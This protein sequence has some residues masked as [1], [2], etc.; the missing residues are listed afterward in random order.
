MDQSQLIELIRTLKPEETAQIRH[1]A[2]I[3]LFTNGRMRGQIIPLLDICLS[4]A[5]SSDEQKLEKSQLFSKIFPGQ[6]FVEGKLE[7][8]MVEAHK[9]VRAFLLTQRYFRQENEFQQFLDFS[10]E[11]RDRG[12]DKRYQQLVLKLKKIQDGESRENQQ[13]YHHK[14]LLEYAQYEEASLRNQGKGDLGIPET[15]HALELNYYLNQFTLLNQYLMQQKIAHLQVPEVV[16]SLI[17]REHIPE[18]YLEESASIKINYEIFKL[19]KKDTP[20]AVDIQDLFDL[21]LS[22]ERK[23]D[24]K[25]LIDFYNYLRN[26]CVLAISNDYEK[27]E[28]ASMLHILYKDNLGRGF[29]HRDGKIGQS[30]YMAVAVNALL[31]GEFDW[32]L[33][34]IEKYKNE[35]R[36]DN[37]TQDVYRLN[38]ANY[39]FKVG[40]FSECL[41]N[42]P[43]TPPTILYLLL[44]KRLELKSYYELHSDLLPYKLDAFKMFLSRTSQKLLSE[45]QRKIN[46]DFANFLHQLI[47]SIPGDPKRSETIVKRLHEKKQAA[48]WRWLLEKAKALKLP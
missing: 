36:D 20:T 17:D 21:L 43:D 24:V 39:Y 34:F 29:L 11:V 33:T 7:K 16:K 13:Y 42:L 5:W 45:S 48:E 38:L 31:V 4:H 46:T 41:D 1:F 25:N 9:V 32:A 37:E 3:P 44:S 23:I 2:A 28:M 40:R 15:L 18:K 19:L 47:H 27:L 35:V 26:L 30:K 12:L 6:A 8:V 22:H 10:E 14:F